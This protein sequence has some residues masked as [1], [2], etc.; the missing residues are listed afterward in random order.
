[1]KDDAVDF[2]TVTSLGAKDAQ[3]PDKK[4]APLQKSAYKYGENILHINIC[5]YINQY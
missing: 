1:M 2:D 3:S 4:I 5:F